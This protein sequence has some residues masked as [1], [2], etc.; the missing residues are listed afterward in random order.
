M[1]AQRDRRE[2]QTGDAALTSSLNELLGRSN[3]TGFWDNAFGA[4]AGIL[5]SHLQPDEVTQRQIFQALSNRVALGF[6]SALPGPASDKDIKFLK[7]S[8]PQFGNTPEAN[9]EIIQT[10]LDYVNAQR[11]AK[12]LPA[13]SLDKLLLCPS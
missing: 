10:Q 2:A 1:R 13:I 11:A 7:E 5:P 9:Q 3:Q 12:G 6:A 8:A 4:A